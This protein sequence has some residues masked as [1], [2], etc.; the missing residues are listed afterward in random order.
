MVIDG[1][2]VLCKNNRKRNPDPSAIGNTDFVVLREKAS[3]AEIE[4]RAVDSAFY[5]VGDKLVLPSQILIDIDK[6][7]ISLDSRESDIARDLILRD[8]CVACKADR[9]K[10]KR[11]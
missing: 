3:L 10:R 9:D 2:P 4:K 11:S 1:I 6:I 8:D 7:G 5:S